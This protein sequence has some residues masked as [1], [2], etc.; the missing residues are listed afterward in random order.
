MY[1]F[2]IVLAI[3]IISKYHHYKIA[4]LNL[5]TRHEISDRANTCHPFGL[6]LPGKLGI[7]PNHHIGLVG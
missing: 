7:Q 1:H 4:S 6:K 3:Y 5:S 2:G